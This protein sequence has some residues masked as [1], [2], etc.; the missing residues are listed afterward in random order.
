M[1]DAAVLSVPAVVVEPNAELEAE[2]EDAVRVPP[3]PVVVL[4]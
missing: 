1:L 4:K 3:V 2:P